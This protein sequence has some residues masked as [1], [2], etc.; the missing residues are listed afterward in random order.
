EEVSR[1]IPTTVVAASPNLA[2]ARKVQQIL[3]SPTFRVYTNDDPIG[4][5]LG[6]ALK[7]IIAL[8][9]GICDGLGLGDNTKGALMTRGLAE[10]RRLGKAMGANP[11]TFAGLSGIG[12]LITTSISGHSRNR[13]V[14]EQLGKGR[15]LKGI[16]KEMTQVAEGVNTTRAAFKLSQKLGVEMPITAEVYKILF[17]GKNPKEATFDLMM[18]K[19]KPEIW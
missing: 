6:G 11:T 9:V 5:E 10:I 12:D 16:L 15:K 3:M 13:Y 1:K 4:V 14:G 2:A 18:R 19:A 8:A 7:N 17:K